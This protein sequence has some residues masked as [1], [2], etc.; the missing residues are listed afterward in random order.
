MHGG[1]SRL[2]ETAEQLL[3]LVSGV[4]SGGFCPCCTFHYLIIMAGS[5]YQDQTSFYPNPWNYQQLPVSL[6]QAT[7]YIYEKRRVEATIRA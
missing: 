6:I 4:L 3:S 5:T 1:M 7:T 2:R